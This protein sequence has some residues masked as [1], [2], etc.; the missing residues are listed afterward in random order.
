MDARRYLAVARD[1]ADDSGDPTLQAQALAV[2]AHPGMPWNSMDGR[3]DDPRR[4]SRFLS[5]ALGRA[6]GADGPT[7]AWLHRWMAVIVAANGDEHSFRFHMETA[8]HALDEAAAVKPVSFLPHWAATEG[9]ETGATEGMGLRLLGRADDADAALSRALAAAA[10]DWLG[11]R[12][13]LLVDTAAVR[14]L[15]NAPEETCASLLTALDLARKAG[16]RVAVS[17]AHSVR[18]TS[19]ALGTRVL[20]RRAR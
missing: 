19:P 10:P 3:I 2:S 14:V 20:R 15:Q 7:R 18:S 8:D 9:R 1:I 17:R 12:A 4:I 6:R 13:M 16:Y 5:G 11:W